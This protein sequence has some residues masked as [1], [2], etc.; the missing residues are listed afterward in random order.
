MAIPSR[1]EMRLALLQHIADGEEHYWQT[2]K[3]SLADHFALTASDRQQLDQRGDN[4]FNSKLFKVLN[5]YMPAEGLVELTRQA[6]YYRITDRGQSVLQQPPEAIN[7]AFWNQFKLPSVDAVIPVLLQYLGDREAYHYLK[8]RDTLTVHFSITPVQQ[9]ASGGGTL[10]WNKC[11]GEAGRTLLRV[12]FITLNS[13]D[14]QITDIGFEV[15]Q[16]PPEVIDTTFLKT[17]QLP[18]GEI[19]RCLLQHVADKGSKTREGLIDDLVTRLR[20]DTYPSGANPWL[21]PCSRA[22]K[23]LESGGLVTEVGE[24]SDCQITAV[25]RA[26]LVLEPEKFP[27]GFITRIQE[28]ASL[29]QELDVISHSPK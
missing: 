17:F 28:A 18:D 4:L 7:S 2:L 22:M 9:K 8:V 25:G 12:D 29:L 19:E 11:W 24:K 20:T 3:E 21:N 15:L 26:A 5:Y 27:F 23:R 16:N 6:G 10:L 14:Y 13:G 1:Q